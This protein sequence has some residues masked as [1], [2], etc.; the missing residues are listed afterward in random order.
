[1]AHLDRRYQFR[2]HSKV[3]NLTLDGTSS[4]TV[5][6]DS[7]LTTL[8]TAGISETSITNIIGNGHTVYYDASANS[9]LGRPEL[10]Y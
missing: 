3:A 2:T 7:Y 5:T 1:M 6:A 10:I 8:N 4:W 9:S